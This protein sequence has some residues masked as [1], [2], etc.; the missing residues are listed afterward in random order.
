[1]RELKLDVCQPVTVEEPVAAEQDD[2]SEKMERLAVLQKRI[3]R[4]GGNVKG[5]VNISLMWDNIIGSQAADLDLHVVCP[6]GEL[7][8]H[9]RRKSKCGG[10]LDVDK[11]IRDIEPVE[12]VAWKKEP[13]KGSYKV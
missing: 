13:E 11:Q 10:E 7:I 3:V 2:V 4:E 12:N 6:S 8:S 9:A 5:T 1:M